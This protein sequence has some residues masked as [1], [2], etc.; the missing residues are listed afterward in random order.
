[1]DD[2]YTEL[3]KKIEELQDKVF[4]KRDEYN[5]L[6]EELAVLIDERHPERRTERIKESLYEAYRK[7]GRPLDEIIEL[8]QD[9]DRYI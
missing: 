9:A 4:K 1:M 6:V 2:K 3:D 7:S 8:I 5:A